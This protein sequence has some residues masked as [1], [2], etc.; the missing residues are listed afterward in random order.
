MIK[1]NGDDVQK[2]WLDYKGFL[3]S[4]GG[5]LATDHPGRAAWI[6]EVERAFKFAFVAGKASKDEVLID[7][8][9]RISVVTEPATVESLSK[10]AAGKQQGD[11]SNKWIKMP[12]LLQ[13]SCNAMAEK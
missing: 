4:M 12:G 5:N 1:L 3:Q 13:V 9:N 2:A 11:P 10:R 7:L 6:A 8:D